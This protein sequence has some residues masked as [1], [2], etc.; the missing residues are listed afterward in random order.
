MSHVATRLTSRS[1]TLLAALAIMFLTAGPS[2]ATNRVITI[3]MHPTSGSQEAWVSPWWGVPSVP[4]DPSVISALYES[5]ASHAIVK[6]AFNDVYCVPSASRLVTGVQTEAGYSHYKYVVD[7]PGSPDCVVEA[8]EPDNG[9]RKWNDAVAE[10]LM[11]IREVMAVNNANDTYSLNLVGFSRGGILTMKTARKVVSTPD[12]DER[13]SMINILAFDPVPGGL[14]PIGRFGDD[15]KLDP[16]VAEYVGVYAEHE[17]MYQFEPVVPYTETPWLTRVWTFRVAGQHQT[18]VAIPSSNFAPRPAGCAPY[19]FIGELGQAVAEQLLRS[20]AWGNVPVLATSPMNAEY[21]FRWAVDNMWIQDYGAMLNDSPVGFSWLLP[22]HDVGIRATTPVPWRLD[23]RLAYQAPYRHEPHDGWCNIVFW[24]WYNEDFV[25][26]L[27]DRME[28][29]EANDW[30]T[31]QTLRADVKPP[32]LR[33]LADI[34]VECGETV[35]APT[36]DDVGSGPVQGTTFYPVTYTRPGTYEIIW[37]FTDSAGN[38]VNQ[39]QYVKVRDTTKPVILAPNLTE[40]TSPGLCGAII[41]D[42]RL[43]TATDSCAGTVQI[44]RSGVPSGNLFPAGT[45]TISYTATD[46]AGNIATASQEITIIDN[47]PPS[48]VLNGAAEMVIECHGTW[49]D[50]GARATDSCAG[51]VTSAIRVTGS[52]DVNT[53]GTYW[54]TYDVADPHGNA[55]TPVTRTVHVRDTSA[56]SITLNGAAEMTVECHGSYIDP[57]AAASDSCAGDLASAIHTHGSVDVTTP[58]RYVL[59]YAVADPSG[60]TA[61]AVR[62]VIVQDTTPPVITGCAPAKQILGCSA[63]VPDFTADVAAGDACS[64]ALRV[65]QTPAAGSILGIGEHPVTITVTDASGNAATCTTTFTVINNPP[66]VTT[67]GPWTVSE[68]SSVLL[69]ATAIDPDGSSVEV[70]WDLDGDGV[71]ETPG[72][73]VSFRGVEGPSVHAMAV[74]ASDP[75]G[76]LANALSNV[77]VTN[78]A[79]ILGAITGP[80]VPVPAGTPLTFTAP[81]TDAGMLDSHAGT[82]NWDDGWASPAAITDSQAVGSHTF[83]AAGV[84]R[85]GLELKDDDGGSDTAAFEYAIVFDPAAGFVTG[86][87]WIASPA[88]A[89]GPNAVLTGKAN[90]GFNAKYRQESVPHGETEFHFGA[91]GLT[92]HSNTNRWL[93]VTNAKAQLQGSGTIA[94]AGPYEFSLTV[95]DGDA[96]SGGGKDRIRMKI[97]EADSGLVV[98]DNLQ[99][100]PDDIDATA[101]QEIGGGNITVHVK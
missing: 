3:Y 39:N 22:C 100:A 68:G 16:K 86:G 50:P 91:A 69:G 67:N 93:V 6:T 40:F 79:P 43:G 25:W 23:Y 97:W 77:S 88:G 81:F 33:P 84:Y 8:L 18:A 26:W 24:Y 15:F 87:G 55:A 78:A 9:P 57:G 31:L 53:P 82:W 19:C 64:T 42:A 12:V 10:T 7:G 35:P 13:V 49:S 75:C 28:T 47:A 29:I 38:G 58:G 62:T 65:S 94:G 54:L 2:L 66:A 90:F 89:Y 20:P 101:L 4:R 51:D 96:V 17:M 36:L 83:G 76:L 44:T 70:A 32:I 80:A 5:D 72:L 46:Q 48:M 98:Y 14:D 92:F 63:A 41:E 99:G 73:S 27:R 71:F 60:N 21:L 59:E 30:T 34:A 56:P 37:L 85:V 11:A 61:S 52:V 45:T 1:H 95:V 74:Q